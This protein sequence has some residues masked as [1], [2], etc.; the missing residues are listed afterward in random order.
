MNIEGDTS[1]NSYYGATITFV[2]LGII[3]VYALIRFEAM[4]SKRDTVRSEIVV[5]DYIDNATSFNFDEHD[6]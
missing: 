3:F 5:P 6:Y 1:I 4:Q 2:S